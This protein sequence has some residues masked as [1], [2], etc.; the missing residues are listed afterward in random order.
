MNHVYN[1]EYYHNGCGPIPYEEPEYWNQFFGRIADKIIATL[2]PKTV[3]D[4]GCAMGYLVTALRDRGVEAYG[5]DISE[6]AISMVRDDIKPYCYVGSLTENLPE[7][8]PQTFDLVITIEVLE[9]LTEENGKIAISKLCQYSDTIIFTSTPNDF[10]E[11]THINVQQREYWARLFAEQGFYNDLDIK[12]DYIT[13]YAVCFR[14]NAQIIRQ[15]ES[16]E[17]NIR[18][19]QAAHEAKLREM[20]KNPFVSTIYLA[21]DTEGYNERNKITVQ[22]ERKDGEIRLNTQLPPG[23]SALRFDPMEAPCVVEDLHVY[24]NQGALSVMPENAIAYQ[25]KYVFL[26]HDPRVEILLDG[27]QVRTID[28][29]ARVIPL[30]YPEQEE[31]VSLL[32]QGKT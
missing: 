23:I 6:Y 28:L 29:R 3:L 7:G 19:S 26:D 27:K 17:R 12:P 25:G 2:H 20:Q 13:Y 21:T 32:F 18:L 31:I 11:P 1:A 22:G 10:T 15:I 30:D 14:K 16:Y 5:V 9:H 24:S 8:L 4:A